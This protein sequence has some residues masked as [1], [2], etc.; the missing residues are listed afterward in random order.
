MNELRWKK[1]HW[2]WFFG[3][4]KAMQ[5]FFFAQRIAKN[6]TNFDW[7]GLRIVDL[8]GWNCLVS[9]LTN[10]IHTLP[11]DAFRKMHFFDSNER[12]KNDGKQTIKLAPK[13][14]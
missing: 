9:R 11:L 8:L 13:N 2:F 7:N 3:R 14:E 5:N 1:Y 12:K 6:R 4:F 10:V